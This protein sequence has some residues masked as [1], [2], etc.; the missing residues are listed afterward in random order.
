VSGPG[1][2][3]ADTLHG[4]AGNDRFHTRDG[5]ADRIDCGAGDDRALLDNVDVIVDATAENPNG[6]C[7]RVERREPKRK[8]DRSENSTQSESS[9]ND[10]D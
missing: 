9:D 7:E 5:E 6:S 2:T 1:D 4:E 8:D 3:T 10:R